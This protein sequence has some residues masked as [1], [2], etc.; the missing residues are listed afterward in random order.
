M[1]YLYIPQGAETDAKRPDS[2][3]AVL[4]VKRGAPVVPTDANVASERFRSFARI[5]LVVAGLLF[6]KGAVSPRRL[7]TV[8]F[9]CQARQLPKQTVPTQS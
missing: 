1:A 3:H 9:P 7:T 6:D 4:A 2:T 5:P 8:G